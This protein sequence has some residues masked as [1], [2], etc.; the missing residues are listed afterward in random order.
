MD[1]TNKSWTEESINMA[2]RDITQNNMSIRMA[3]VNYVIPKR[4]L[5][6]KII[7]LGEELCSQIKVSRKPILCKS[8]EIDIAEYII[9]MENML[10]GISIKEL[11]HIAYDIATSNCISTPFSKDQIM[12][13]KDWYGCF[14]DTPFTKIK[15]ARYHIGLLLS[16]IY[17]S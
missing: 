11:R 12:A 7:T 4:T 1:I 9:K 10:M 2:L 3:S 16:I 5:R 14:K 17:L 15:N 8:I 13:G 6:D